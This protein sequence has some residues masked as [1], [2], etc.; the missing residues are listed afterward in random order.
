MPPFSIKYFKL[1]SLITE[2]Y[3]P[4]DV[5]LWDTGFHFQK[6]CFQVNYKYTD[7][8]V[9]LTKYNHEMFNMEI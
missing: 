5:I 7:C 3:I 4:P 9:C 8:E 6:R 1:S 2:L